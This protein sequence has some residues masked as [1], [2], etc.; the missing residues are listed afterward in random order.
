[1]TD[2]AYPDALPPQFRLHWYVLERVLGQGGFG[3]T[4]LARDSN[5]DQR[6][7]IKEY[8]PADVATRRPDGT[9][10]S[11]TDDQ[12]DRYRWGLDRFIGEARTLARFDHPNIVRVHSVF[13]FNDTAYMVMRFEE[14][15]NF[16]A[17]LEQRGALPEED[18]LR[19]LVPILDGLEL[20]HR[21]GFIHRDIK[22]SN[23][24]IRT[25]GTPVLLDFGSARHAV[26]KAHTL[27]I[28]V[29][30]GYAP[31]EQYYSDSE[32]QGPW[33]DIY[34]LGAT[35]YR[36]IA[37]RAPL[38]AIA[39]SKGILGSTRDVLVPATVIGAGRYSGKLLAA[40]DRALA[41]AEKDRP[42]TLAEWRQELVGDRR[43][44]AAREGDAKRSVRQETP[45][46]PPPS[47]PRR[48]APEAPARV[49]DNPEPQ[50]R[51]ATTWPA[52]RLDTARSAAA[53]IARD[54]AARTA[55]SAAGWGIAGAALAAVAIG[56]Y[57]SVYRG[58]RE[59]AP[60]PPPVAQVDPRVAEEQLRAAAAAEAE[61]KRLA[62]EQA[63]AAEAKRQAEL[64][65]KRLADEQARAA[66]TKRQA[67]LE[68]KRLAD[69]QARAAEAKRQAELERKRTK[70]VKQE[71]AV[72]E[73]P[74]PAPPLAPAAPPPAPLTPAQQLANADRAISRGT[75]AEAAEILKPLAADSA[76][77]QFRLGMLY[78]QGRGVARSEQEAARLFQRAADQGFARAQTALGDLYAAGRGVARDEAEARGWYQKAATQGDGDAQA[79]LGDLYAS[80]RGVPQNSFQAYVWYGAAARSGNSAA[81]DKQ[82][83]TAAVLQPAEIQQAD[84]LIES[85]PRP[86]K[87]Q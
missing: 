8:L 41:F 3:I 66:E 75:Y 26:G 58:E 19:I 80:G 60:A 61:R 77:A 14:G 29:A 57:L 43:P 5:L 79:K 45:K 1:M 24:H 59:P 46:A 70:V 22:P 25:D 82:A 11:R 7:A 55:W 17:L 30:P 47:P 76:A 44:E 6:V 69:E 87:G 28:L 40:I 52:T 54:K 51:A 50:G 63:R 56:I 39:R 74:P 15:E 42:Q 16:A 27:T 67:E 78:L 23:I 21:A 9:I 13:E 49:I 33:T 72:P 38:D 2:Q 48:E 32:S 53:T 73:A 4:Y 62:D 37:G 81:R 35:C 83:R 10:R 20:V 12:R 65:R 84:R 64:E 31:F 18:L 68:R 86:S 85:L 71:P 34:S 36:A